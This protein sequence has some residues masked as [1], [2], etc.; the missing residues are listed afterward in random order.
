MRSIRV[1]VPNRPGLLAEMTEVLGMRGIDI[2]QIVVET[3]D[4]GAVVRMEVENEDKALGALTDAGYQAVSD[5][6]LLARIEDRPG[7][8]AS[9]SRRFADAN[10]NI[11]SLHHVRRESGFALV[12]VSTDDN[13]RARELLGEAA[14]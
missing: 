14:L 7:S 10:L 1:V 6:V 9:L 5:D 4:A 12:A 2:C 13:G 11:R 8:L 3:S